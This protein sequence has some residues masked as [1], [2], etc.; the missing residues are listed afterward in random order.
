MASPERNTGTKTT[1]RASLR[2]VVLSSG[3]ST[4]VSCSG[5][6]RS[7]S[8]ASTCAATRAWRWNVSASEARLRRWARA[9]SIKGCATIV[10]ASLASMGRARLQ[11]PVLDVVGV[12]DGVVVIEQ[13][14]RVHLDVALGDFKRVAADLVPSVLQHHRPQAGVVR[15]V[16]DRRILL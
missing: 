2:T 13:L 7:T 10:M 8:R 4:V 15:V 9:S 5:R 3:V 12:A 11:Q 16:G 6:S 14:Q 1:P